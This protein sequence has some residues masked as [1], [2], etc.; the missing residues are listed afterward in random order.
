MPCD[1]D[2]DAGNMCEMPTEAHRG[3]AVTGPRTLYDK[4]WDAH[5]VA[6][7]DGETLLYI[8][9]HLLHEVT[10]PQAFAG[11]A[12]AGRAVRRPERALALSDHN[13]PTRSEEHTSE[14]QSLMRISYAVFCLN[15]KNTPYSADAVLYFSYTLPK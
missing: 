11:L 1:E 7:D 9:L 4:I 3:D 8:D 2:A 15:K 14:L 13:V 5:A 12:A 6:E 10:S